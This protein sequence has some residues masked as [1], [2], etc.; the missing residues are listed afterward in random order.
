G[1]VTVAISVVTI[2]AMLEWSG[3]ACTSVAIVALRPGY[4]ATDELSAALGKFVKT[5]L[6]AR[7]AAAAWASE[8]ARS[9]SPVAAAILRDCLVKLRW[10][11]R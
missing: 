7:S 5:R 2:V 4:V 11:A 6:A 3:K 8:P 1:S 9:G 10:I